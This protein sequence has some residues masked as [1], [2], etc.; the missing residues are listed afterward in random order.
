MIL[1][2][3]TNAKMMPEIQTRMV[4]RGVT[5]MLAII[6]GSESEKPFINYMEAVKTL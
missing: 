2:K 5:P 1:G 4:S 3:N 6:I